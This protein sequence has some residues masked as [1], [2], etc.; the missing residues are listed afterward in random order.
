MN[1]DLKARKASL[2]IADLDQYIGR[3][4]RFVTDVL[5]SLTPIHE[6]CAVGSDS[7]ETSSSGLV[8]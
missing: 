2:Q 8:P 6:S 3:R 5:A 4:P 1:T 7:Q